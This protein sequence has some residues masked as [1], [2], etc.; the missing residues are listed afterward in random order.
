MEAYNIG[1][2]LEFLHLEAQP[3]SEIFLRTAKLKELS[4]AD[5]RESMPLHV[6]PELRTIHYGARIANPAP[7]ERNERKRLLELQG[8]IVTSIDDF[9]MSNFCQVV[10][11]VEKVMIESKEGL[12]ELYGYC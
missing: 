5:L 9:S 1:E 7:S 12:L 4:L 10:L 3:K 8:Y 2:N 11:C 6:C